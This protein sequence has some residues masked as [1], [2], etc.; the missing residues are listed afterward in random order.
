[1]KQSF[2]KIA[3][4]LV[5]GVLVASTFLTTAFAA[6]ST[7]TYKGHSSANVI[8][9]APGSSYTNTDLFEN[10]KSVMPGDVR[11]ETVTIINAYSGC[12]YIK[13][14]MRAVLHD[15]DGNPISE[16]VLK[17]LQERKA[18]AS[19]AKDLAM[20]DLEYMNDFLDQFQ[21]TIWNGEKTDKQVIYKG[22]PSSLADGFENG[23]VYL[24][25]LYKN[26]SMKLL[27]ELE[28]DIEMD[29]RYADRIGEVDWVFVMEERTSGGG[30]DPKPSPDPSKPTQPTP[31]GESEVVP[32][33][34]PTPGIIDTIKNLPKTGDDTVAWPYMVL[35]V[36]GVAGMAL[37]GLRKYQRRTLGQGNIE[38]SDGSGKISR[39]KENKG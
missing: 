31:P 18:S 20:T 22:K 29:N 8:E 11:N 1:M 34:Q 35:L 39:T 16:A 24:G 38:A 26:E 28:A 15:E 13:V 21:L 32:N 19:D 37:T 7:I 23:N 25:T 17:E 36:I 3:A 4:F 5:T 30:S 14:W 9:F 33:P 27:V 12:T 2:K 6:E 10:F